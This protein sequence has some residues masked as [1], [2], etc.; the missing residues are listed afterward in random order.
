MLTAVALIHRISSHTLV[1]VTLKQAFPWSSVLFSPFY[2]LLLN[3][4]GLLNCRPWI[5]RSSVLT[6][7]ITL[8]DLDFFLH[9]YLHLLRFYH[10]YEQSRSQIRISYTS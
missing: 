2:F 7:T 5:L 6:R 9:S 1:T 3:L 8:H 4:I 10:I